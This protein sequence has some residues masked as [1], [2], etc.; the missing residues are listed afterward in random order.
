MDAPL[1]GHADCGWGIKKAVRAEQSLRD[2]EFIEG[3][4]KTASKYERITVR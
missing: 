4:A 3:D 2:P 1:Q